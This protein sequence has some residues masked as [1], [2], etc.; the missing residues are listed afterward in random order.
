MIQ[1]NGLGMTKEKQRELLSGKS[2]RLGFK[3]VMEKIKIVKRS[4]LELASREM[5][6]TSITITL[7]GVIK[8]ESHNSG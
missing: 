4:N 5:E 8:D 3:N 1:D 6:G 7:A 2:G